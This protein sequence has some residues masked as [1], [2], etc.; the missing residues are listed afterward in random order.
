MPFQ[1]SKSHQVKKKNLIKGKEGMEEG[2][3]LWQHVTNE[4]IKG[5]LNFWV[6]I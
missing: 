5:S 4:K 3:E 2:C 1:V 6:E